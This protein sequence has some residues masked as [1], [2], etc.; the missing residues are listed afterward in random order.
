MNDKNPIWIIPLASSDAIRKWDEI[1]AMLGPALLFEDGKYNIE[2]VQDLVVRDRA[3]VWVALRSSTMIGAAVTQVVDYPQ[4]AMLLVLCLAGKHFH[5][6]DNIVEDSFVPYAK[7]YGCDGIE[8]YGR[9]G[10]VRRASILG[11]VPVHYVYELA[12]KD[13]LNESCSGTIHELYPEK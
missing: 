5:L 6:W 9:K 12:I 7:H 4:K 3:Q 8:F 10:W 11:F 2:D 1:A 13:D